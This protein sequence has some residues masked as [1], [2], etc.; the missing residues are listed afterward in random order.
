M[1]LLSIT[2]E[3]KRESGSYPRK[4]YFKFL[5]CFNVLRTSQGFS[6]N[7]NNVATQR[8]STWSNDSIKFSKLIIVHRYSA[9]HS[10]CVWKLQDNH[11]SQVSISALSYL[12]T[13]LRDTAVKPRQKKKGKEFNR[14]T[15]LTNTPSILNIWRLVTTQLVYFLA[16]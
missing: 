5:L 8:I 2:K 3:Q 13:K 16:N 10:L 15:A 9:Y 11:H 4:K 1:L 7:H 6:H 12:W 14:E